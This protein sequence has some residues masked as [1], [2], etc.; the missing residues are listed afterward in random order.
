MTTETLTSKIF[1]EIRYGREAK[2]YTLWRVN[3]SAKFKPESFIKN[4][5][6]DFDKALISAKEYAGDKEVMI[7]APENLNEIVYGQDVFRFGKYKDRRVSE[8]NDDKYLIWVWKCG[9]V[10]DSNGDWK[11][12]IGKW[13]PI[14]VSTQDYLLGKGVLV[15]YNDRVITK[16]FSEK[17]EVEKLANEKS[18]YIGSIGDK[19]TCEVTL[20]KEFCFDN[21]F[22][23]VW[24]YNFRDEEGNVIVYKGQC[25]HIPQVYEDLIS[26]EIIKDTPS[27]WKNIIRIGVTAG[28]Y[29]T[30]YGN[31]SISKEI[32]DRIASTDFKNYDVKEFDSKTGRYYNLENTIEDTYL[33]KGMKVTIAGTVKEHSLYKET[34][35]TIIQRI[36]II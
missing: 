13:D 23:P 25:L 7:D 32:K 36:K 16:E 10:K 12:L 30:F 33:R 35:Q 26:G 29:H 3:N 31:C 2:M 8:I 15:Y 19:I 4:L 1:F 34:K 11:N 24:V 22:V 20:E 21:S 6:I 5:S 27:F 14:W 17:L 9:P 28:R 18:E